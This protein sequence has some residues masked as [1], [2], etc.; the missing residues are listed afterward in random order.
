M[1]EGA[2]FSKKALRDLKLDKDH[3]LLSFKPDRKRVQFKEGS[4]RFKA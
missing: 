2:G 1:N 3:N 4:P